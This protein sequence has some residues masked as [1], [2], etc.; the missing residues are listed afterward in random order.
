[1]KGLRRLI[2]AA[3]A[4]SWRNGI[5]LEI[6]VLIRLLVWDGPACFLIFIRERLGLG[7]IGLAVLVL[8]SG[9]QM[10][11]WTFIYSL[12]YESILGAIKALF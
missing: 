1:M 12:G 4:K 2:N 6:M 11:V 9:V 8:A 5:I 7:G 10:A 3:I